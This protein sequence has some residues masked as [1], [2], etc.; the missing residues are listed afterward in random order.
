MRAEVR[1]ELAAEAAAAEE[2][3]A[4][5]G[6]DTGGRTGIAVITVASI[7]AIGFPILFA[8]RS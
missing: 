3:R 6:V 8:K 1:A 2:I 4:A 7:L 5:E